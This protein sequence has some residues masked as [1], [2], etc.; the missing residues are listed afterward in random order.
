MS[1]NGVRLSEVTDEHLG[2]WIEG[3]SVRTPI[4]FSVA[5]ID[6]AV[7]HGMK[8]NTEAWE[9]D[10]PYFE[11]GEATFDMIDDLSFL[12]D[13]AL[14]YLNGNLPVEFYFDFADG[15]CLFR[16]NDLDAED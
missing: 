15:L 14:D 8:L 5:I 12:T 13:V 4:E 10:R 3:A 6:L 16:D 7:S 9:A 11:R 2:C 1:N